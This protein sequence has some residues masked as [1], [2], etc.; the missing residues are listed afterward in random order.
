MAYRETA[1]ADEEWQEGVLDLPDDEEQLRAAAELEDDTDEE[2]EENETDS[3]P[4]AGAAIAEFTGAEVTVDDFE[5]IFTKYWAALERFIE[6][7]VGNRE[8]AYDLTQDTF[9]KAYR[10]LAGGYTLPPE[11]LTNWLYAIA[12]NTA[13][14]ALRH[15]RLITWLPLS[16][17][18]EDR[19]PGAG[20]PVAQGS[21]ESGHANDSAAF[22]DTRHAMVGEYDGGMFEGRVADHATLRTILDHMVEEDAAILIAFEHEGYSV[23]EIAKAF[24]ASE[25]AIKMQLVRAR[26]RFVEIHDHMVATGTL[27]PIRRSN[28]TDKKSDRVSLA[29]FRRN[30]Q[31]IPRDYRPPGARGRSANR[32]TR[33]A[34]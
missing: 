16:I 18:N 34:S 5:Q 17:F 13:F 21:E 26:G 10:A 11:G 19:G 20:M 31:A 32:P 22:D 15:R 25:S 4:V 9:V 33:I 12:R 29:E 28:A 14:D 8:Q 6:S 3:L 23:R 27:P 2:T 24:N 30:L 7:K 1:P